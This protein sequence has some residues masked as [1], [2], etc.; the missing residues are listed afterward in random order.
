MNTQRIIR[1]QKFALVRGRFSTASPRILDVGCGN[2][3]PALTKYWLPGCFYAGAD[4]QEYNL[5]A[6]DKAAMD[7]F[8]PVGVDG[9]GYEKIPDSAFDYVIL[10][11][12]AEHMHNSS[13][14]IARLCG[15]LKPGGYFWIAFPSLR[16]LSLPSA[17][18]TLQFCDDSTH[19]FLPDV[20]EVSNTLLMNDVKIIHAG[21][22]RPFL[23]TLI[24]AIILPIALI[25]RA[26]TGELSPK[27][28]WFILGFEDHVFWAE[29]S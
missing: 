25:R 9:S 20:R 23:R 8:Y 17:E 13:Q 21:T 11:H 26:L 6:K 16:S 15:K 22:S 29:L 12:V 18:G 2:H 19:V 5:D 28:L 1:P 24:G 10:H 3:S 14:M 4:I 27:G 7:A